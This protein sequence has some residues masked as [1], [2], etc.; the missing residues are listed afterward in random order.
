MS[1]KTNQFIDWRVAKDGRRKIYRA[2]GLH[3]STAPPVNT[4]SGV[5]RR[6]HG[7]CLHISKR[8]Y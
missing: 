5:N 6:I 8:Y 2:V 7:R 4:M 1:G 3:G